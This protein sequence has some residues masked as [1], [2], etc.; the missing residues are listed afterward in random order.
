MLCGLFDR[1]V[2]QAWAVD[3]AEWACKVDEGP[4]GVK[5]ARCG[6][7]L[8]L[9]VGWRLT[10]VT[11]PKK[12]AQHQQHPFLPCPRTPN[13]PAVRWSPDGLSVLLV[14]DFAVRMTVWSL[15]D[16]KCTYLPGPKFAAK[17]W[18]F[19]PRADTLAVLEV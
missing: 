16:S 7:V 12:D 4:A 8:L 15:V 19:S 9:R 11:K 13:Q 10:A 1:G 14:A 3:D 6:E 5:A 2:V 17:G 18:A